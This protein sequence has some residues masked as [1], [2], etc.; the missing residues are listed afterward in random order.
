MHPIWRR[1]RV[2]LLALL[3]LP[4]TARAQDN[5]ISENLG[6]LAQ[7]NAELYVA[8]VFDG[9]G[10]ALNTGFLRTPDVHDRFGFDIGVRAMIALVPDEANT[11]LAQPP[12]SFTFTIGGV[13]DT[14]TDPLVPRGGSLETPTAVGEG[15][16]IVLEPNGPFRQ[17]LI[18]D[19]QNPDDYNVV[20]PEGF[21]V[22]AVPFAVISAGVGI[23]WGTEVTVRFIPDVKVNDDVGDLGAFGFGVTHQVNQWFP[24]PVPV[25][26]AAFLGYQSFKV[27]DYLDASTK[28]FGVSVGKGFG[29]LSFYGVGQLESPSA[30]LRYVVENPTGNPALPDNQLEI[31]FSPDLDGG[32]RFGVGLI[33]DMVILQLAGE[34][35]LGDYNAVTARASIGFR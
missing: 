27:G 4:L 15:P 16:G 32:P 1:L 29:P 25:D 13:E 22:P 9:L 26:L 14:Y 7:E 31:A 21:D 28:T 30:D 19:G 10:N 12:S 18:D 34:Y 5:G 23:G 35:S 2:A 24:A 17:D 8:P 11:F 3:L 20:F 33:L 6:S